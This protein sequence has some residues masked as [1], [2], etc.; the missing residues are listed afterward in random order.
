MEF[1]C[2]R[3][4]HPASPS[5][6]LFFTRGKDWKPYK[7][8]SLIIVILGVINP[9]IFVMLFK[10]LPRESYDLWEE[11]RGIFS[12]TCSAVYAGMVAAEKIARLLKDEKTATKCN[13]RHVNLRKAIIKELFDSKNG[14]YSR[15]IRYENGDTERKTIDSTVDSS[16]YALFEFNVLPADDPH[17]VKT[18]ENV[19][20]KLW[21]GSGIG[22]LARY[23]ADNYQRRTDE[24]PG[25][26]WLIS[27]L[28]L[29][30]WHIAKAK[31]QA[32]LD[33][34]Y[35]LIKW[36]A[37]RATETGIMPEQVHPK[38]GDPLSV[39]PLTWSH[40]EYIDAIMRYQEKK[41]EL[42]EVR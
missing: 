37:G 23:E 13:L 41:R 36:A 4:R 40:S 27:T 28:W 35:K 29:A 2:D 21:T 9:L 10:Y 7:K 39:A 33:E 16:V 15:G 25:N 18:M 14:I 3:G 8:I 1:T 12:F 30:K 38:T 26:P 17:I 11:R 42:K 22:G 31:D 5:L 24:A 6:T 19:L 32:D 34:A 20:S